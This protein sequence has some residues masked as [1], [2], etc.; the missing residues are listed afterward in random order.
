MAHHG[1]TVFLLA[2]LLGLPLLAQVENTSCPSFA[3]NP[4]C[5]C[6]NFEDGIFLECPAAT[7]S[8][9]RSVLQLIQ[10][11]IQSLSV[12]DLDRRVISHIPQ[13]KSLV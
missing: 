2:G 1:A 3:A 8:S 11:P 9:L 7:A 10:G 13:R 4:S 5:P 6:Y 12:Y